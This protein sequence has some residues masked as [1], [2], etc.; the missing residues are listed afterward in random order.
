MVNPAAAKQVRRLAVTDILLAAQERDTGTKSSLDLDDLRNQIVLVRASEDPLQPPNIFATAIATIQNNTYVRRVSAV[1]D[2]MV[3][4]VAIALSCFIWS[5]S[6]FDLLF[7]AIG[8]SAGYLMATLATLSRYYL[9]LPVF[10]P[11]ALLFCLV[12]VRFFGPSG[13]QRIP[14]AVSAQPAAP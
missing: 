8:F 12:I 10:L 2:W 11:L 5:I 1:F 6:R 9:W 4:G 13:A 3:I 7:G 14:A